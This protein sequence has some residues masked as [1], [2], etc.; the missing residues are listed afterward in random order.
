[1]SNT[2][3]GEPSTVDGCRALWGISFEFLMKSFIIFV[4]A[5]FFINCT[6]I[7]SEA[8]EKHGPWP[9]AEI[10][11]F[12]I[13]SPVYQGAPR[14]CWQRP[15]DGSRVW[16]IVSREITPPATDGLSCLLDYEPASYTQDR[17]VW[18]GGGALS[19][20]IGRG[21]DPEEMWHAELEPGLLDVHWDG[22]W[23]P[24]WELDSD[25]Y[26]ADFCRA[27]L[28]LEGID[29][30]FIPL[31]LVRDTWRSAD[32]VEHQGNPWMPEQMTI[33]IR[34]TLSAPVLPN[35]LRA[36]SDPRGWNP[37][38]WPDHERVWFYE[39]EVH[40]DFDCNGQGQTMRLFQLKEAG[41]FDFSISGEY[42]FDDPNVE[43]CLDRRMPDGGGNEEQGLD[44]LDDG[45]ISG[46][47]GYRISSD[48]NEWTLDASAAG[49][50]S[51]SGTWAPNWSVWW[52]PD[53]N[54]CQFVLSNAGYDPFAISVDFTFKRYA[55][56]TVDFFDSWPWETMR[57]PTP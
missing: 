38:P 50:L 51:F 22:N 10:Q 53:A 36:P 20:R 16:R 7:P 31:R 13:D 32:G 18:G 52:P 17:L 30:D 25:S 3:N 55:N 45:S 5:F 8:S 57:W 39:F 49:R 28:E 46:V 26:S 6:A 34:E 29:P 33:G 42:C 21:F 2:R 15:V 40:S 24:S 27:Q 48:D 43:Q 14:M 12:L 4:F 56:A 41:S 54:D 47:I 23:S 35:R 9:F 44:W 11:C 37:A 1:M 19:F